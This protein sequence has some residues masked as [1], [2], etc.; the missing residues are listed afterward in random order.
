[1]FLFAESFVFSRYLAQMAD[2]RLARTE[3]GGLTRWKREI[4]YGRRG[5][6]ADIKIITRL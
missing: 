1:M 2:E 5:I 3:T 4:V 6:E